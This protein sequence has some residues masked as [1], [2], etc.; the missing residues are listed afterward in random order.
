MRENQPLI[1]IPNYMNEKKTNKTPD[2]ALYK[3]RKDPHKIIS[4]RIKIRA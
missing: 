1:K 3:E 4:N 2:I